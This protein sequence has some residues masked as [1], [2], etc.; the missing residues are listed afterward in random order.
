MAGFWVVPSTAG[1]LFAPDKDRPSRSS[2]LPD[3]LPN[4][5]RPW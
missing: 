2:C 4:R 3:N 5:S 1:K